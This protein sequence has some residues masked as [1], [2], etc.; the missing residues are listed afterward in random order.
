LQSHKSRIKRGW[1]DIVEGGEL[2]W[3]WS[4]LA[5]HDI[6]MRYRGS[7]LGPFWLTLSTSIMAA[8]MGVL[9]AKLFNMDVRNYLPYVTI[10]L[11]VWQFIASSVNESC[12]TFVSVS[13][14]VQQVRLPFSSHVFRLVY[15]NLLVLSHNLIIL[16]VVLIIFPPPLIFGQ[17]ALIPAVMVLAVNAAWLACLLGMLGARYRDLPP[18]ISNF[19]Q[20]LFFV[21]PIFWR[22]EALGRY[23]V[24]ARY[25][26]LH[27]AIDIVRSP[28]LGV[29]PD[30]ASWPLMLTMTLVG[31]TVTFAFFAR[32]RG[33]I[34]YWV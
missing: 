2:Y 6:K 17:L 11:I 32:F 14:E 1:G 8:M 26:P 30:V 4:R 7:V 31:C 27:A 34:A 5:Y 3:L 24:V 19:L 20:V 33:R 23:L 18:I 16:P 15:R 21:T 28:L 22:P 12:L 25:N 9:Y 13:A 10:G 29:A